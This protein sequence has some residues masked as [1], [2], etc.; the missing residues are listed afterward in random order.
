MM[1]KVS[2]I[3]PV[4]N[5]ESTITSALSSMQCQTL[6]DIEIIVVDDGSTDATGGILDCLAAKDSRVNVIHSPSRGIIHALNLGIA[7]A[8]GDLIARMDGDDISHPK[9]LELQVDL[10]MSHP[11]VSVCSSSIRMFPVQHILGGMARYQDWM[12]TASSHEII[13]RDIFIESPLAHPSVMLR[14]SELISLG[15]YQ[16]RGWAEDYDLWL[17]YHISGKRFAKIEKPL[18]FWR[19]TGNRLTFTDSRYSLENFLRAKAHYLTCLLK[20]SGRPIVLW[21]AGKTGRRLLKHLLRGGLNIE[22]IVDIDKSKIGH[23][24]RGV[25]IVSPDYLAGRSYAFIISAVGSST[26]RQLIREQLTIYGFLELRD[27][28]C[29]A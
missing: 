21:G 26:A 25:S 4:R 27:F 19:Q 16:E 14:K 29:A 2:V 17:R 1:P 12:N 3:I 22:A 20:D 8:G 28:I 6:S 9:R 13:S 15:G 24:M 18:F 5:A 11:E 23:S 7:A 10:M